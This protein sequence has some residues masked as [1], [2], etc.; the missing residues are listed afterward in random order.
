MTIKVIKNFFF[1][2]FP[3]YL[4]FSDAAKFFRTGIMIISVDIQKKN[5]RFFTRDYLKGKI[6]MVIVLSAEKLFKDK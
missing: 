6:C 5:N 4:L 3:Q 1:F 2:Y